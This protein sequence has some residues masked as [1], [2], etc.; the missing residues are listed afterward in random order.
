MHTGSKC[1]LSVSLT[2]N[3]QY[4][5]WKT[6]IDKVYP[7]YNKMA[8]KKKKSARSS[9]FNQSDHSTEL[10]QPNGDENLQAIMKTYAK[11]TQHDKL[12]L[13]SCSWANTDAHI[14]LHT[15]PWRD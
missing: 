2:T 15:A 7:F 11:Q 10:M 1:Q 5:P 9:S 12:Q 14:W 4:Q 13:C 8:N 6:H 3:N